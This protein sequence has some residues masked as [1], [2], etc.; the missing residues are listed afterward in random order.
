MSPPSEPTISERVVLPA[1]VTVTAPPLAGVG[2]NPFH[3][4]DQH[5]HG[6][7][8]RARTLSSEIVTSA[9]VSAVIVSDSRSSSDVIT[10]EIFDDV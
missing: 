10:C 2:Q 8:C 4:P 1:A 7:G 9:A 3:C 6:G 5:N